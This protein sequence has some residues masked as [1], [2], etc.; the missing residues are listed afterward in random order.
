MAEMNLTEE[1]AREVQA[2]LL[3]WRADGVENPLLPADVDV[4]GD[5]VVDAYGLD[6]NDNIIIVSGASLDA[7][8]F[9]SDGDGVVEG[10]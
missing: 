6:D 2:I 1:D 3:A 4:D 5:G 9:H 7:T 10:R 8:V